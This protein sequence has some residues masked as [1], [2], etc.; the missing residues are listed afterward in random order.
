MKKNRENTVTST[1][2]RTPPPPGFFSQ[3]PAEAERIPSIKPAWHDG[4]GDRDEE[5]G[6]TR[7]GLTSLAMRVLPG[8]PETEAVI[9][10][11]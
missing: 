7:R 4:P 5:E 3:A 1:P 8:P 2:D 10:H 9:R 6:P 11:R